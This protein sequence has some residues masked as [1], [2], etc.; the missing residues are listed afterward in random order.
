MLTRSAD[1]PG[2]TF[3]MRGGCVHTIEKPNPFSA[4]RVNFFVMVNG[5]RP[6]WL[7]VEATELSEGR[8][9]DF[10]VD[11]RRSSPVCG[12][13][14]G[15]G[16]DVAS[17]GG[18][19]SKNRKNRFSSASRWWIAFLLSVIEP[20][21]V[22]VVV[23]EPIAVASSLLM[24][25]STLD[26]EFSPIAIGGCGSVKHDFGCNLNDPLISLAAAIVFT[27]NDIHPRK[28]LRL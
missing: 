25:S 13:A 7:F 27:G 17:I 10:N 14:D 12:V 4:V 1:S 18:S 16:V 15:G 23:D 19:N 26:C 8:S 21:A 2:S 9:F 6:F 20:V 11:F 3:S 24:A 22:V 5:V 28:S